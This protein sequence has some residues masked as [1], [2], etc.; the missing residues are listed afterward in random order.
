MKLKFGAL[1]SDIFISIYIIITLYLRFAYEASNPVTPL[2]SMVMGISF[3][4]IIIVLIKL[5]IFNPN[6]FG[7]FKSKNEKL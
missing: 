5:K 7:L 2:E 3:V 1:F 6:W 4:I